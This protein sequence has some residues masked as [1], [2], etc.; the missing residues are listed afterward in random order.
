ML[1]INEKG[2]KAFV[3]TKSHSELNTYG[4]WFNFFCFFGFYC[5]DEAAHNRF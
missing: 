2:E 3:M 1:S 4:L 5:N